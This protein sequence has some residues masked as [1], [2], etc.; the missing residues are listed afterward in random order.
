MSYKIALDMPFRSSFCSS[1]H[2]PLHAVIHSANQS[3]TLSNFVPSPLHH[4]PFTTIYV[5]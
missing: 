2:I 5:A 3:L 4:T 1:T